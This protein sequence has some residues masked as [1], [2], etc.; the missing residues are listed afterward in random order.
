LLDNLK[1]IE[2][3]NPVDKIIK[4]IR[5]LISEGEII[6]GQKLPPER[7]LADH[8]GVSRGQVR[9]ALRK[10]E[11]YG[12][13]KTVPQSGTIVTGMG[14]VALE[15]LITDVL[16]IE[17]TDFK[18][19]VETRILL[20]KQTSSL[21]AKRRT[22]DDIAILR[23]ALNAHEKKIMTGDPAVE[24]DLMFHIK[25][26]EASKNNVLKSLM[27]IITPDII[28]NFKKFKVCNESKNL[29]TRDSHNE[30]LKHI[31]DQQPLKASQAMGQHL[32]E[33]LNFSI[34]KSSS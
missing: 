7:K 6:S 20:E 5:N 21:A 32:S 23:N 16:Q 28:K 9:E 24:E 14:I 3:D 19:L 30:I 27:M 26:A 17:E 4:Q 12:I 2:I 8:L 34:N 22:E 1:K 18:S 31:I 10:L 15:G 11:F 33:L 29:V 13:L 25:I